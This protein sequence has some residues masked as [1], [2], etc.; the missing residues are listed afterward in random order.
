MVGNRTRL[1][2]LSRTEVAPPF[3][4]VESSTIVTKRAFSHSGFPRFDLGVEHKILEKTGFLDLLSRAKM[5]W[6]QAAEVAKQAMLPKQQRSWPTRITKLNHSKQVPSQGRRIPRW[7]LRRGH[8]KP[9]TTRI[10]RDS[11]RPVGWPA[12]AGAWPSPT[13]FTPTESNRARTPPRQRPDSS[14]SKEERFE[15]RP[16]DPKY[17][18]GASNR[19]TRSAFKLQNA[20]RPRRVRRQPCAW[21]RP[22]GGTSE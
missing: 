19:F 20:P 18:N 11:S 3:L 10:N 6:P 7:P 22:T 2:V 4:R 5:A 1:K 12:T 13:G 9:T 15:A 21:P 14:L 8:T 16:P 17:P